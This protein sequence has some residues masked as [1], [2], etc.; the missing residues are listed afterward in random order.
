MG[1][2]TSLTPLNALAQATT[3]MNTIMPTDPVATAQTPTMGQG[4]YDI[5]PSSAANVMNA[6]HEAHASMLNAGAMAVDAMARASI[7]TI[8]GAS[9]QHAAMW[10]APASGTGNDSPPVWGNGGDS[11]SNGMPASSSNPGSF[12]FVSKFWWQKRLLTSKLRFCTKNLNFERSF[13]DLFHS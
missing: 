1:P 11:P 4:P 7:M 5:A 9:L 3:P 2:D 8:Q 13:D 10:G 6:M 12:Y